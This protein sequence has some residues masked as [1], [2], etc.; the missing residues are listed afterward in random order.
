[1]TLIEV[2]KP[3]SN[4]LKFKTKAGVVEVRLPETFKIKKLLGIQ[5]VIGEKIKRKK[6]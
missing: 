3:G 5:F 6:K 1:M 2:L 4:R